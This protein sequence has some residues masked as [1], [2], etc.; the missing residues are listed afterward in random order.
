[1]IGQLL[2]SEG[3]P[4]NWLDAFG[5]PVVELVYREWFTTEARFNLQFAL[6]NRSLTDTRSP[7]IRFL[8]ALPNLYATG[9]DCTFCL[10]D[11]ERAH[12]PIPDEIPSTLDPT[13]FPWLTQHAR[14]LTMVVKSYS[15]IIPSWPSVSTLHI[16][17]PN[18]PMT[19]QLTLS[20]YWPYIHT[21]TVEMNTSTTLTMSAWPNL[22]SLTLR[23]VHTDSLYVT[24]WDT[25]S[26]TLRF[27]R[28][29]GDITAPNVPLPVCR[30]L[31]L[32]FVEA[33]SW[34]SWLFQHQ[35]SYLERMLWFSDIRGISIPPY[36][37]FGI[38]KS[39]HVDVHMILNEWW[40]AFPALRELTLDREEFVPVPVFT[41]W[42]VQLRV[43]V[44]RGINEEHKAA[45]IETWKPYL[46]IN[47]Q[48]CY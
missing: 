30:N 26:G 20:G 24:D 17:E 14:G 3:S 46:P 43:L 32:R 13:V 40:T 21:L 22:R 6:S 18:Y 35:C 38:L 8:R 11:Y 25:V 48:L 39:L 31:Q 37:R 28:V 41:H 34:V 12:I 15:T 23:M 10:L 36:A 9:F 4:P 5:E 1:M 2:A 47:V 27:L 42:P 29:R 19:R 7:W 44:V 16:V 45:A 33:E